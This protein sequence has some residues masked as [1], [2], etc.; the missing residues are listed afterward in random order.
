MNGNSS[1]KFHRLAD[2]N[3]AIRKEIDALFPENFE[4]LGGR[5]DDWPENGT[6]DYDEK[7]TQIKAGLAFQCMEDFLWPKGYQACS[8]TPLFMGRFPP[9]LLALDG[10]HGPSAT[11]VL[12][13]PHRREL[14][15]VAMRSFRDCERYASIGRALDAVFP[16]VTASTEDKP[17]YT[18]K[19]WAVRRVPLGIVKVSRHFRHTC[20]LYTS[21]SPR[22]KR[23]SRMPSSA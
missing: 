11:D 21:P 8:A 10:T 2:L 12:W 5:P 19:C 13:S 22:D 15:P 18:S 17:P 3:I 6:P 14:Q 23:Q 9:S 1:A 7:I 4:P 16:L 20:L